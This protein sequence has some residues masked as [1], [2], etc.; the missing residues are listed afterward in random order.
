MSLK[1]AGYA[2]STRSNLLILLLIECLF[3]HPPM[4]TDNNLKELQSLLLKMTEEV[5][6]LCRRHNIKYYLNGGNVI[7]A[8]RHNGFIPWDDDM[9]IMLLTED[10][11][12]FI[13]VCRKELDPEKWYIQEAWK[14]W[15]GCFTKIR[16]KGTYIED[17]GE[18]EGIDPENRGVFIDVFEIVDAADSKLGRIAQYVAAKL[19]N[20]H[21][22]NQRGYRT[23]SIIKKIAL[24]MAHPL[25]NGRIFNAVKKSVYR[26]TGKPTGKVGSFFGMSRFHSAFYD[27][28]DFEG[29]LYH[30]YED[31]EL[32]LPQGYENYLTRTF[33]DYMK[34]PPEENRKP[35]HSLRIDFGKYKK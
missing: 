12:K 31:T 34:L 8:V 29:A 13:E 9:D 28:G 11:R 32:P 14:E 4:N 23:D 15:P 3:T 1:N 26:Y 33:G 21:S 7:G 19:L 27:K 10:Y 20:A 24:I 18:W 6:G 22:L 25:D 2:L 5:D 17:A 16:L 30:K 35:V